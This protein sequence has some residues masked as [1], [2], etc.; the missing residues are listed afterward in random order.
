MATRHMERMHQHFTRAGVLLLLFALL[1]PAGVMAD[2]QRQEAAIMGTAITVELWSED[3]AQGQA[4]ISDI[5]AEMR[6]IDQLMSTYNPDSQLSFVNKNAANGP[7]T[8]SK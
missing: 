5:M 7:G 8:V 4:L 6:R 3:D 1:S 2:W